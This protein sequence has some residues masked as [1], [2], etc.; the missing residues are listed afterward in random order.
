MPNP[1]QSNIPVS[2]S[3]RRVLELAKQRYQEE[4]GTGDWGDF[5][6]GLAVGFLLTGGVVAAVKAIENRDRAWS[7]ECPHCSGEIRVVV[8]GR[9]PS[10]EVLQCPYC[11]LDLVVPY[12][13]REK[14][15]TDV[16]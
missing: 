15:I 8:S 4:R 3:E 9:A 7:V 13:T 11:G 14:R 16:H 2:K 5:L 10:A 12:R 6:A 1:N